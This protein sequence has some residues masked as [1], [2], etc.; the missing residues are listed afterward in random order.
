MKVKIDF[1]T[2]SSS[3]SFIIQKENLS[4]KQIEKIKNHLYHGSR[5]GMW[6]FNENDQSDAWIIEDL[7][8][9][10]RGRTYMDNFDMSKFLEKNHV[11]DS[12]IEWGD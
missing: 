6:Y 4:E 11:N 5:M 7:G 12:H 8:D 3:S 2:N 10:I 1:V 9:S